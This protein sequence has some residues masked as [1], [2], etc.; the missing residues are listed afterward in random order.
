MT[1][2]SLPKQNLSTVLRVRDVTLRA[3]DDP[4]TYR[5]KLA[6][7]V[8]DG[9]YEFVGL[10]DAKGNTLEI[11]Q[12]ALDGAGI[13][14]EDIRGK[15]FWE[16]RWWQ[17]SRETQE[18]QRKLI[19]RASAGEFVRC[20]VEIYG[21]ASGEETIVVDYSLLPIRDCN[22]QVVFL[23]PE[24]RNITDKNKAEAELARRNEELQHL[25]EKV[26]QLD[27]AKNEFFANLSHELR[28]P[29]SLIL[30][31]I[32]SLLIE[33][34]EHKE[35]QRRD[36]GVIQR[37]AVTLLKYV[38]DLLDLAKLEE[39]KLQL[40]YSRVDISLVTRTICAHFEALA[41]DKGIAYVVDVPAIMNV[42]IDV[43]KYERI[44]LNLLSNAFRFTPDGGRIRCSL[45]A[46]SA[47]RILLSIQ[48]S[49]PGIPSEQRGEIFGRFNQGGDVEY[50][51]F[52]GTGLGLAI[53][54]D[55]A[56]LHGGMVVVSDAPGEGALFQVELPCH[57]PPGMYVRSVAMTSQESSVKLHVGAW[58]ME[59]E[60][61]WSND[62][63]EGERPA[64]LVVED[65]ID[66]R[67][68]IGRVLSD[69]YQISVAADGEQALAQILASPPDL[70]ITDLMM[71]KVS[72]QLL[73][74]E[75][76]S[77][78]DLANIPILV[79][80]AKADDGLRTKLLAESVQDY[81]VKPFSATELRAR[82]QNLVTMKRARDALQRE[83]DSQSEDLALL[84]QQIISNRQA[85]Q[86]SHDALQ[87]SEY[88]WRAVYEGSAA[89]IVLT[90][91]DGLIL[92]ANSA[93]Q[94][95]IGYAE[96]ELQNLCISDLTPE[97]DREAVQK[98]IA[99]LINGHVEDYHVQRQYRRKSGS[100]MWAN[101]RVS[102]IPS[103]TTQ[104]PMLLSVVDDISDKIQT[105]AE[106]AV[107]RDKLTRVMRVTT[108]GELV[109]SI[110]HEVNQPLAAI[111]TNG[112]AS[113][114]WLSSN[115]CNLLEAVD[116]VH[117][118][119]Q[120]AK[121]ASDII[122][123]IR[124]F[125]EK[126][127]SQRAPVNILEVVEDVIAL[128]HDMARSQDIEVRCETVGQLPSVLADR[129]QLQ[130]VILNLAINGI[131]AIVGGHSVR[132]L[133]SITVAQ[134]AKGAVAV[135]VCDSGPGL[136]F[137]EAEK[138]FDAFYTTKAEGL[139]MGLA[140]SRSIVEAHG[141]RLEVLP[142]SPG[143]GATFSFSL[144][145]ADLVGADGLR[146]VSA[147]HRSR[148]SS[149]LRRR[150]SKPE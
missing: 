71:P 146:G 69:E 99:N 118:T 114:R 51:H 80:S 23:L 128:I 22:G 117:R 41:E 50:L 57:A 65:N 106:L 133:L 121:R 88:R 10:L 34:G 101:V 135:S 91:L 16:A 31:S 4:Q 14:L 61:T 72:G 56:S 36:L 66:M 96:E 79:L 70:V 82:V 54:K 150:Q 3:E 134:P 40:H 98:R 15:P 85:L 78:E 148:G 27:E 52:G 63:L 60:R 18:E 119:I 21:R 73:V 26:R 76:R 129:V 94:R 32:E 86:R 38:N 67:C 120:D 84:T 68:F 125:L 9:L 145:T 144:P 89:G 39:G 140:I 105:E 100:I 44:V 126:G 2:N 130:Q 102:L 77:R 74:E 93:F 75:M 136:G 115:P 20:D 12:A 43:E 149:W 42:E 103:L 108:M 132:R 131:E 81:V 13:R 113:L 83:L 62:K 6:R 24:G 45:S 47:D 35:T 19:D 111:V 37:N 17:L 147:K 138:V 127:E 142:A 109:A 110:A 141:G 87:E 7:V 122:V 104:P 112:H 116:A 107:A 46:T 59:D 58:R 143:S 123:R 11:N 139:G 25:L 92:S 95:M 30:G 97:H 90:S 33:S 29:L 55:F 48:D 1:S 8:L 5:E 124:G 137:D 49:G 53:V 28:T 64:V